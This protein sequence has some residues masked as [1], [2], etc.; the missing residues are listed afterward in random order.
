MHCCTS[1]ELCNECHTSDNYEKNN[2]ILQGSLLYNWEVKQS[3]Y[4]KR[5]IGVRQ[6]RIDLQFHVY[7]FGALIAGGE[8]VLRFWIPIISE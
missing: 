2:G 1:R 8:L 5:S 7:N 6:V 4:L 3:A